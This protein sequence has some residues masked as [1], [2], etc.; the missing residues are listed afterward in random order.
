LI[1]RFILILFIPKEGYEVKVKVTLLIVVALLVMINSYY[2]PAM[3]SQIR[4]L[5]TNQNS[6]YKR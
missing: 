2:A 1:L 6:R 3:T 5:R 4:S